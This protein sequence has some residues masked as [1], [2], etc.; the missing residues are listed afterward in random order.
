MFKELRK[1]SLVYVLNTSDIPHYYTGIVSSV[2]DPYFPQLQ[3]GQFNP[4]QQQ[5]VNISV[6]VNGVTEQYQQLPVNSVITTNGNVTVSCSQDALSN[7]VNALL[8]TSNDVINSI[9]KHRMIAEKCE[10]ILKD[11][12]PQYAQSKEQE[13]KIQKLEAELAGIKKQLG[14]L[15]RIEQL[16]LESKSQTN[17]K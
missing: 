1:G 3:P 5:Y 13:E 8:R 9:D 14:G 11:L 17:K 16:L 6:N 4:L 7:E 12:N 2:S 15:D 10:D